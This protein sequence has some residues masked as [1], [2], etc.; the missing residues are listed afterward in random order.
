MPRAFLPVTSACLSGTVH[1]CGD[2]LRQKAELGVM[3]RL[4]TDRQILK[5]IFEMYESEYPGIPVGSTRGE[6]DPHLPIDVRAVAKRLGCNAELLFGR[7]YYHL[8]H[9]YRYKQ[10]SGSLVPL[11]SLQAGTKRHTINFPYLVAVLA[12]HQQEYR[13]RLWSLGI[14]IVAIVLSVASLAVNF[15]KR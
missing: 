5:C 10:D 2:N 11:F 14:S 4:P 13:N 3:K 7:L 9:R 15:Y 6:N 1:S 8:D 12:E